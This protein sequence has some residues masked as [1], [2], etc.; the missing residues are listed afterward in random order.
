[1]MNKQ[2]KK[3]QFT[4][5]IPV[6]SLILLDKWRKKVG[7]KRSPF[8]EMILIEKLLELEHLSQNPKQLKLPD[9]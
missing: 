5:S 8:V 1:M 2:D 3:V 6:K 9:F 4:V 7:V